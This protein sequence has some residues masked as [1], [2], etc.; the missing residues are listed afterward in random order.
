[1]KVKATIERATIR[2]SCYEQLLSCLPG[3]Y[4]MSFCL[5]VRL[6][7]CRLK[8]VLLLHGGGGLSRRGHSDHIDLFNGFLL[9]LFCNECEE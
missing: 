4:A 7:V 2:K 6:F 3:L 5:S 9:I 8:R 1:M